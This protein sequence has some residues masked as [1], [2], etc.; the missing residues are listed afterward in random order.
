ME[1][2]EQQT[3]F[4][5]GNTADGFVPYVDG[6]FSGLRRLFVLKGGPG[7]GKSTFMKRV[8]AYAEVHGAAVE[9]YL[10]SSDS[11]SLDGVV[12]REAGIGILD[13]TKPHAYEARYPGA[14]ETLI[15]PGLYWD[16]GI[17]ASRFDL[18]RGLSDKKSELYQTVYKHLGVC[19]ALRAERKTLLASVF[20]EEKAER[21][22]TRMMRRI[23]EGKGFL[24]LPRQVYAFG[25]QG[26]V[27]LSTYRKMSEHTVCITDKRGLGVFLLE[28]MLK[29]AARMGLVTYVSRDTTSA[30]TALYFPEKRL[31]VTSTPAEE[32]DT[33]L[34]TERFVKKE[35][36][37]EVRLQLRFLKRLEEEMFGHAEAL[38]ADIAACHFELEKVYAEAMNYRAM[39]EMSA[40]FIERELAL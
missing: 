35:R 37:S 27:T 36:L 17:L 10:C 2:M 31:T 22:V 23:G 40:A 38:F 13:G 9:R 21:A 19:R 7:T 6:V 14:F 3:F 30:P 12:V 15:D 39:E 26:E 5:G 4:I 34:N 29:H 18:I 11:T 32:K 24:L 25:M 28:K 16:R 1:A 20:D 33:I 8:A